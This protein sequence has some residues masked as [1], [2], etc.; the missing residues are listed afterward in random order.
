MIIARRSFLAGLG[1]LIAAP[2]I[3][4]A[5]N[6]MPVSAKLLLPPVADFDVIRLVDDRG[7]QVFRQTWTGSIHMDEVGK[8]LAEHGAQEAHLLRSI[9]GPA[10]D[11]DDTLRAEIAALMTERG[12]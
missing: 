5:A 2:A 10:I 7:I 3:V 12:L 4:S 11:R 9:V 6:I 8:L 1:A